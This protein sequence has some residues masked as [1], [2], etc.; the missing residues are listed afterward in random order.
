MRARFAC[1]ACAVLL[2]FPLV[3]W[4]QSRD[5]SG[6]A[7][8]RDHTASSQVVESPLDALSAAL[9]GSFR[10]YHTEHFE[11]L[12]DCDAGTVR[13]VLDLAEDTFRGVSRF[14]AR[15]EL[16]HRPPAG[17]MPML[18]FERYKGYERHARQ[19]GFPASEAVPGYFDETT[20]ICALFNFANSTAIRTQRD[21]LWRRERE[22]KSLQR[23][24]SNANA[25]AAAPAQDDVKS[26]Q[27]ALDATQQAVIATVV[28]HEIAHQVLAATG[29]QSTSSGAARWLIEGTAMQFENADGPNAF[30]LADAL[31]IPP[32]DRPAHAR[33]VVGDPR[34]LAPGT[35]GA[36]AAY[37]M[38]WALVYYLAETQ[39]R[40]LA[41]YLSTPPA[42]VNE[43][44][45]FERRF[46]ELDAAFVR[47]VYTHLEATRP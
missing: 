16:P 15:L 23:S 45:A 26:A 11:I 8:R 30:R 10:R 32:D 37:A 9:G 1:H 27:R 3:G 46:G 29:V 12:S 4:S 18:L 21:E 31:A 34:E 2:M 14:I 35:A 43:L 44:D 42:G 36:S 22:Q 47:Q 20:G 41:S 33:R 5:A 40:A 38:A 28:R 39:P 6:E 25:A 17:R 19:A 13:R 24:G 7:N